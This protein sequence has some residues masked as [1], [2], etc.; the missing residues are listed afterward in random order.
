[1]RVI[2]GGPAKPTD[3]PPRRVRGR[4]RRT[5]DPGEQCR[6]ALAPALLPCATARPS[7][8][9][10]APRPPRYI[11]GHHH[12]RRA[13]TGALRTSA[14]HQD[15]RSVW[16]CTESI[17]TP[18][19]ANSSWGLLRR[20]ASTGPSSTPPST[21]SRCEHWAADSGAAPSRCSPRTARSR[22]AASVLAYFDREN[23]GAVRVSGFNGTAAMAA[24]TGD[25]LRDGAAIANRGR[26]PK[27]RRAGR[28]SC[29]GVAPADA[30]RC[31]QCGGQPAGSVPR[32]V[33]THLDGG[34]NGCSGFSALRALRS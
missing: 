33:E 2:N 31:R 17:S 13:A 32:T 15:I 22:C 5:P 16:P 11:P 21:M 27:L 25:A 6:D 29:A 20:P 14:R 23:A 10:T 12:R 19:Q 24:V 30:R 3:K 34:C 7:S 1:M 26:G 4:C 18:S 8:G 28:W 9:A